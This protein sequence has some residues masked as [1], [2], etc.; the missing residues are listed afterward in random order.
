MKN[1]LSLVLFVTF[2]VI[3][4]CQVTPESFIGMLPAIPI[5]PCED[6]KEFR[7]AFTA[8]LD[9]ISFLID[10]E[11]ARRDEESESSSEVYEKQTMNT[12]ANQYG[13]SQ[14][15]LKKLQNDEN[16]SEEEQAE[17][18]NKVMKKKYDIS[19][20]EVKNLDSLDKKAMNSWAEAYSDQK[21]AE[22]QYDPEKNEKQQLEFKSRYEL[23]VL[24]KHLTDS[25][26]A[27]ESKFAQ[28]FDEI[29]KDPE[30][31]IMLNNIMKLSE[32]AKNLMGE[33]TKARLDGVVEQLRVEMEKYCNNYTNK[34]LEVLH[35]YESYTRSCLPVCYKL[36]KIIAQHTKLEFGVEMKQEPGQLGIGKVADYLGKLRGVYKY[37]LKEN[38]LGRLGI[39]E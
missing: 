11:L 38:N 1:L 32:E 16:L 26:K 17:L 35:R 24:R 18:I 37:N 15:E 2:N 30:Q 8:K 19:L 7:D 13:L 14:E 21:T 3:S 33:G 28:Q 20:K 6:E 22:V 27:I 23:S 39:Y 10:N 25:L 31:K 36:E 9:S 5:N 12:I 34:Y 4:L 29:D